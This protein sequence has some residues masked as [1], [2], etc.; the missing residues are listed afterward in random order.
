MMMAIAMSLIVSGNMQ[1]GHAQI[2]WNAKIMLHS[3]N[4]Y[5]DTLR[6]GC[7]L[8]GD[9]GYQAGLDIIDT[10][11]VTKGGIWG[12]DSAIPV[13]NC[14]NLKRDIKN[15]VSGFQTFTIQ[16]A[17]T[18]FDQ[19][20]TYDYLSIDTNEFKYDN[21]DFKITSVFIESANGYI[22]GIDKTE[23]YLYVGF[24]ANYPP[25]FVYDCIPLLFEPNSF[26]C[27]PINDFQMTLKLE[28]GFNYY[29]GISNYGADNSDVYLFPNPTHGLFTIKSNNQLNK[30]TIL[31]Q[32]GV[33]VYAEAVIAGNKD[34]EI[35]TK[36]V[37]PGIYTVVMENEKG[38]VVRKLVIFR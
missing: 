2:P 15:F 32:V 19:Q 11:Y 26:N 1:R 13:G 25:T 34:Y 8:A 3:L 35:D 23:E 24:D 28:I 36:S 31:N 29:L 27:L 33:T 37:A 22:F 7:D 14:F 21:G 5:V 9:A 20:Q 4:G 30:I 12:F 18:T 10:T 6:I 38:S 16:V 17:D